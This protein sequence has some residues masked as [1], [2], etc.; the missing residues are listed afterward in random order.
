MIIYVEV[1]GCS[2][3]KS[4]YKWNNYLALNNMYYDSACKLWYQ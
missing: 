1:K 3:F 4:R 2:N